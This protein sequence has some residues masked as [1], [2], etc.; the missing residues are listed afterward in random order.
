MNI[1]CIIPARMESTRFPGKPMFKIK[2]TPMIEHVFQRASLFKNWEQLYVTTCDK[3]IRNFSKS[4]N[5][6]TSSK[7]PK[8]RPELLF[9]STKRFLIC[10]YLKKKN[11]RSKHGR[12]Y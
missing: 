12:S 5:I 6:L 1:I 10:F 2:G 11:G 8:I 4:K 3:E 9:F 7:P